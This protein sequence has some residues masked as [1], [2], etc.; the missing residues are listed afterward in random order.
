[1]YKTVKTQ[2]K[3]EYIRCTDS[4]N[5]L[6]N[7][8]SLNEKTV[9]NFLNSEQKYAKKRANNDGFACWIPKSL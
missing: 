5:L 3:I 6:K 7:L 2:G 1:M 4:T 9:N 8:N